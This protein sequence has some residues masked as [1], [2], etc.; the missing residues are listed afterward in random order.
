MANSFK[1]TTNLWVVDETGDLNTTPVI[2]MAVIFLPTDV[3]QTVII[4]DTSDNPAIVLR[5]GATDK[6]PV[7][8]NCHPYGREYLN[9]K[10]N[11]IDAGTVYIYLKDKRVIHY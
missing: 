6:T 2:V 3:N 5:S 9:L 4:S 1:T 7:C 8:F 11:T 10:C